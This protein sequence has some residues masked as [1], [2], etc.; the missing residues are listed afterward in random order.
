M[1]DGTRLTTMQLAAQVFVFFIAGFETSSTTASFALYEMAMN[2]DIQDSV[3]E[4]INKVLEQNNGNI[5][6]ESLLQMTLLTKV[7][8]GKYNI[9]QPIR[10]DLNNYYIQHLF[11]FRNIAEVSTITCII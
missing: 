5:T 7:I 2:P 8:E 1:D 3:R 9:Y 10:N 4:D 11:A 6:Y